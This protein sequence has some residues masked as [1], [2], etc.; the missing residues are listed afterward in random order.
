MN[1][2]NY[3]ETI[4]T[5]ITVIEK[6][7]FILSLAS[8]FRLS[9]MSESVLVRS[10]INEKNQCRKIDSDKISSKKVGLKN[11]TRIVSIIFNLQF[12]TIS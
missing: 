10:S 9:F 7:S 6:L 3:K 8:D 4:I 2:Y 12:R 11:F 5:L 1:I